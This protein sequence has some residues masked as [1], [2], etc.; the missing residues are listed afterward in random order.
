M[1]KWS[2][3]NTDHMNTNGHFDGGF[4]RCAPPAPA[5]TP[6]YAH[7]NA[8]SPSQSQSGLPPSTVVGDVMYDHQGGRA[9]THVDVLPKF[10]PPIFDIPDIQDSNS[11]FECDAQRLHLPNHHNQTQQQQPG[12]GSGWS[13]VQQQYWSPS[14]SLTPLNGGGSAGSNSSNSSPAAS[15]SD[16]VA[17]RCEAGVTVG[18]LA[19]SST[20]QGVTVGVL[21]YPLY[22]DIDWL[23]SLL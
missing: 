16:D 12:S 17:G 10:P 14:S 1:Q 3:Y 6:F 23:V 20:T 7:R 8:I 4:M 18:A 13:A 5:G 21:V 11:V 15:Y 19:P 22:N 2:A 9:A